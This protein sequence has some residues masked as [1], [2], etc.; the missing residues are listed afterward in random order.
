[1]DQPQTEEIAASGSRMRPTPEA[2]PIGETR[3]PAVTTPGSGFALP[4][5]AGLAP[6]PTC[7][8]GANGEMAT[9]SWLSRALGMV[10]GRLL[11]V[12]YTLRGERIRIISAREAEPR[13]RRRYH[14]ENET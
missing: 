4:A 7:G 14:N 11:F 12:V 8:Q 1:M 6:C 9:P 5:Q 3:P 13:E 10:E 2:P